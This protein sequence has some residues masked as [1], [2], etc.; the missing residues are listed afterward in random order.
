MEDIVGVV[1]FGAVVRVS[2]G[3]MFFLLT[4]MN[5]ETISR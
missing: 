1:A 2:V 3:W 5:E 4:L